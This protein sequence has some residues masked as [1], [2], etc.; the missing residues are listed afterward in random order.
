MFARD[1]IECVRALYGD[2]EHAQY[3]C[4]VPE[5]HYADAGKTQRLYHDMHTGMWWWSTQ[6]CFSQKY[7]LLNYTN[8]LYY[9]RRNLRRKSPVQLLSPSFFPPIKP[10]SLCS[11]TNLHIPYTL[12]LVIFQSQSAVNHHVKARFYLH[13]CQS[14]V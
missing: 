11:A 10:S 7:I 1:I 9:H 12:P 6:V 13:I 14:H 4:F 8:I 2:P 5:K 3:L